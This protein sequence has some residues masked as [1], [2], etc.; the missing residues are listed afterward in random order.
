VPGYKATIWYGFM[1]PAKTP[2]V[3]V[4]KLHRAIVEIAQTHDAR[5]S[6]VSQGNDVVANTPEE[7]AKVI[8]AEADKWGNIGRKL[9]VTLD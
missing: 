9:G 5:Q 1:A 4:Q 6:F 3:V 2:R 7:F 8:K